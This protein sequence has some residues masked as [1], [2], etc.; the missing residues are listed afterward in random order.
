M[1]TFCLN[2]KK[3]LPQYYFMKISWGHPSDPAGGAHPSDSAGEPIPQNP[4]EGPSLRSDREAHPSD[5]AGEPMHFTAC[6]LH[7]PSPC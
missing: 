4:Q 1:Q 2:C 3:I 5:P 7:A 6:A